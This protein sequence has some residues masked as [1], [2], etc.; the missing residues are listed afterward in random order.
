M[1]D[2]L[3]ALDAIDCAGLSYDEWLQVG[4]ALHHEGCDISAWE[5]WSARDTA[6]YHPGECAKKWR[7]FGNE[8]SPVTGATIFQMAHERG[9]SQ[10]TGESGA[11]DWDDVIEYDGESGAE[12]AP[13]PRKPTEDLITYLETLFDPGDYV[14]Y[15]TND[16]FKDEKDGKWKP[17]RGVYNQTAG[18]LIES[19]RRHPDDLGAT[20][21]DWKPEAGAWI[22]FN[23]LDGEGA[24][25][26]NVVSFR[27]ALVECDMIPVEQQIAIYKRFELPVAAL[28]LSA[29][30]SAH[31]IVRVDAPDAQE[32]KRRVS[33]LYDFLAQRGVKVDVANRNPSRLSRMPGATRGGETQRLLGTNL[34]RKSWVDWRDYIEGITDEYPPFKT[35][36]TA[37]TTPKPLAPELIEGVLR[38]GHKM[39]ISGSSKAGKSFL[40]MELCVALSEGKAWLGFK[41]RKSRVLYINFEIDEASC[42][43]R[44]IQI[45]NALE[46]S[47]YGK[48]ESRENLVIWNMRGLAAPLNKLANVLIRRVKEDGHF[49]AIVLDPI[50]KVITG[51]ENSASEMAAFCG[52]F[53]RICQQTGCAVIYCHHHSKGAQGAKRAMDRASGSGVFA[54]DPD[55]Q[56]DMIELEMDDSTRNS[57]AETGA[58][59]WRMEP[60]LR[61]F[62]NFPPLDFWFEYPLHRIDNG[63]LRSMPAQ[64]TAEAGRIKNKHSKTAEEAEEEFRRAFEQVSSFNGTGQ[65]SVKEMAEYLGVSQRTIRQRSKELSDEYTL[66]YGVLTKVIEEE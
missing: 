54:R 38:C 24:K 52:Q 60:S 44:L 56:L 17:K 45:Y 5:D 27:Y 62:K 53:D 3:N 16:V 1:S 50:Y 22:R 7:T 48:C 14:G 30:K 26:E 65:A 39:L 40:L 36:Q 35:A 33:F 11:M 21:G 57:Y 20:V 23:A 25:N 47:G 58:T 63:A 42:D 46:S 28:V 66:D 6:R 15:V 51:D 4:M 12:Y 9:W 8:A 19:L 64:G 55:A 18:E 2:L 10:Y 43:N 61:E 13:P 59:A 31:A 37:T 34:G 32:Y 49:D 29:G 41:C